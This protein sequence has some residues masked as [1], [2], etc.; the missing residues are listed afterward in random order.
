M[1]R[2]A[3]LSIDLNKTLVIIGKSEDTP[4]GVLKY[5]ES[6]QELLAYYK[7]PNTITRYWSMCKRW[8]VPYVFTISFNSVSELSD[9]AEILRDH[10]FGYAA[11]VDVTA[12]EFYTDP[13]EN[14]KVIFY[15]QYLVDQFTGFNNTIVLTSDKHARVYKNLDLFLSDMSMKCSRIKIHL[16]GDRRNLLF[17]D[18][19]LVYYDWAN[20]VLAAAL[21]LSD[22]PDYPRLSFGPTV[23]H[24]ESCDVSDEQIYFRDHYDRDTTVENLLNFEERGLT[25]IVVIDKILKY[26]SRGMDFTDFIGKNYTKYQLRLIEKRL[27]EYLKRWTGYVIYKY[28]ID[29]I[30]AAPDK[31]GCVKIHLR[32]TVWPKGTTE[33]YSSEVTL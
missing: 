2:I 31:I 17:V 22:I 21:I 16:Q 1:I 4:P 27:K 32:Y 5:F 33:S 23:F 3:K 12:G 19:N 10:D 6:E 24:I 29:S 11:L 13:Y 26:I 28:T 25:K 9:V 8:G 15:C 30:S 7:K 18:N 20:V 14:G